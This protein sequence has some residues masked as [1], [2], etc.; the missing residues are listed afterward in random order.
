[1][2][3]PP[4]TMTHTVTVLR[5]IFLNLFNLLPCRNILCV[6]FKGNVKLSEIYIFRDSLVVV[7]GMYH[8]DIYS[9]LCLG[10]FHVCFLTISALFYF[11]LSYIHIICKKNNKL[12]S[13]LGSDAGKAP[14]YALC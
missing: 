7:G 9:I 3:P 13:T 8:S 2:F 6:N 10:L 5:L 14:R 11:I 1:M 12:F 4:H